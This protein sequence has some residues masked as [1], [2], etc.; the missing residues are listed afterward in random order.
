[1]R[2]PRNVPL[3]RGIAALAAGCGASV[4]T[5]GCGASVTQRV[6]SGRRLAVVVSEYLLRP[7]RVS[8]PAGRLTVAVRNDGRLA[9]DL[10][11]ICARPARPGGSTVAASTPPIPPGHAATVTATLPPGRYTLASTLLSDQSLGV[12]G[13][14]TVRRTGS[15]ARGRANAVSAPGSCPRRR[16][17]VRAR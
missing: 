15:A 6:G 14:L 1:M 9:H 10:A 4:L 3:R 7:N 2:G 5:A 8:V 13:T 11:I 16:G 17:I 12:N